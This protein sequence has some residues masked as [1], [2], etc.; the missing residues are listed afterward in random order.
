[1]VLLSFKVIYK[2]DVLFL[3]LYVFFDVESESEVRF[4]RSLLVFEL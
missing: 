2:K 3:L 4:G 1:M